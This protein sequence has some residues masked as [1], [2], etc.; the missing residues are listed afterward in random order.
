MAS[1]VDLLVILMLQVTLIKRDS[2][3]APKMLTK[4]SSWPFRCPSNSFLVWVLLPAF[5]TIEDWVC[6]KLNTQW[7]GLGH[8]V[9]SI[10]QCAYFPEGAWEIT[11]VGK[12][13]LLEVDMDL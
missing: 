10:N 8:Q 11:Q 1:K 6:G 9:C 2:Q 7:E 3:G 5:N 4:G 12:F 13:H